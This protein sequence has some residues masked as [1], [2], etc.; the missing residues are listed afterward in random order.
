MDE[1][2]IDSHKLIFHPH[3]VSD[4]L[5][6]KPVYPVYIDIGPYGGCNH[7]C[8]FCAYNYTKYK[9]ISLGT[10]VLKSTINSMTD[11][12]VKAIMYSGEGEP[13]LHRNITT[14]I[15]HTKR[16]GIDVAI[17]TNGV[18]FTKEFSEKCLESL[19]WVKVSIDAGKPET[20]AKIHAT[21]K[22][23]FF[24]LLDNLKAAIK[25]KDDN[26]CNCT[27]GVQALL[28][29]ANADELHLLATRLK[30]MGVDYLVIKPFTDH[31]YRKGN[32]GDLRYDDLLYKTKD[33]LR[34]FDSQ[35][36]KVIVRSD[37]FKKLEK[38]RDYQQCYSL[39]FWAVID[40][41]GD[42]YPCHNFLGN[43]DYVYGNIYKESFK[44]IW[45]NRKRINVD[46]S[47]CRLIC[48]M[49]KVNQY[50]WELKHLPKH[51]NFI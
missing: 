15:N 43:K 18:L 50:L 26:H 14:I 24:K 10:T 9:P 20:Y 6:G 22:E 35:E 29:P 42:V 39:D 36:F 4:W 49:D 13:L 1:Y 5:K 51:V 37:T 46:V 11:V 34:Y 47:H 16:K 40:A 45:D 30:E 2:R 17:T 31:P 3:T 27:I 23:D 19:S 7:R 41:H 8:V 12:G 38:V 44:K 25:I 48:R 33:T 21:R 28:L 32:M